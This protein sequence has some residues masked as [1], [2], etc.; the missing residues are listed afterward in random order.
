MYGPEFEVTSSPHFHDS[1]SSVPQIM[2]LVAM[3]LIPACLWGVYVFGLYSL[4]V[5]FVS[6]LSA[7]T[8]EY[9]LGKISGKFTINDWSAVVTGML[10]GMNMPPTVPI[11]VPVFA[12]AFAIGVAKWAFGG[13]GKNWAN[14]AIAGRV[15]VFFSFTGA[16]N[17]YII[18]KTLHIEGVTMASPLSFIKT[19]IA[20][21][22]VT[23]LKTYEILNMTGY[24][25][26][27]FAQ[28]VEAKIGLDAHTVDAFFGNCAGCIGEVS[29]FCLLIGGLFLLLKKA[30]DWRLPVSFLVSFAVFTWIF[31]GLRNG[32]PLF[33]GDIWLPLFSGGLFLG[34]FFMATD[35]VTTPITHAG[36]IVFGVGCGLFTFLFRYYGS[37]AEAASLGILMMNIATP[38]IDRFIKPRVFGTPGKMLWRRSK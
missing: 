16:M 17:D 18:P 2:R 38:T 15:F 5:L 28:A 34:A 12:S 29:A 6:V 32:M 3:S 4:L 27:A 31:G 14:P 19:M 9:E 11:Y 20:E 26:T 30:M 25:S 37:L 35:M 13:L 36:H 21:G 24:P 8:T 7:I 33:T 22:N 10:V 1:T 23:G